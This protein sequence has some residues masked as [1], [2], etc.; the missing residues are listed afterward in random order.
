MARLADLHVFLDQQTYPKKRKEKYEEHGKRYPACGRY[1]SFEAGQILAHAMRAA[2]RLSHLM[3]L[4][5]CEILRLV[6]LTGT[7]K[8]VVHR[9][10]AVD[11]ERLSRLILGLK[12]IGLP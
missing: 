5:I 4:S 2:K 8:G 3:R 6:I 10:D 12:L 11:R 9:L 1:A 7:I